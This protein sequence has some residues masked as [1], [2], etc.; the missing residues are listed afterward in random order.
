VIRPGRRL[1][2]LPL[3]AVA[4][5]VAVKRRLIAEGHDVIDL[6]VGDGDFPPPPVAVEAL[7]EALGDSR[8]SRY[9]FQLG[10]P[11]F[12]EAIARYMRRRFGVS[13]DPATEVLPLLGSKEGLAH[14]PFAVTSPGDL[15]V[16]PEP[17]YP[18][19]V[20][21]A[22]LADTEIELYPLTADRGFLV[23]LEAL[24]PERLARVRLVYANYPNNPTTAVAP[25]EYLERTV[26]LCRRHGIVLAYD[27]PYCE[28]GFDGYVAP[29]VLEV[30]G[31]RGT[32]IEFHSLSK[33]FGLTGWRLGWAAGGAEL[34]RALS[35]VKEYV[36]T[37]PFLAVQHAGA[38]TLD[39]AEQLIPPFRRMLEERR[40]ACVTA[41]RGAGLPVAPPRA[42]MYVWAPVPGGIPSAEL[43][44]A[45]LEQEGV[46]VVPGSSFGPG[47]EGYVRVALT[48]GTDRLREA[49]ER[50]GRVLDRL[51]AAGVRA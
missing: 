21:G 45:L 11:A 4:D 39:A 47:G 35:R 40:D 51:G 6:S 25:R 12:R 32:A 37:G 16:L 33:S 8:M 31:A 7:R 22:V 38:R 24:P 28:L 10:L 9:G 46:L 41:F 1:E 15:C 13:V 2:R 48:V 43:S 29:S 19:Y 26:A 42:T 3:Y 17:G 44:R 18:P 14:L 5:L 34:I 49:G 27:N 23:E 30:D 20:G 36:D 50:L